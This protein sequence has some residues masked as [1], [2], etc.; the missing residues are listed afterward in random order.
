MWGEEND[1]ERSRPDHQSSCWS[2]GS[3]ENV[4]TAGTDDNLKTCNKSDDML[5]SDEK[6][7]EV[8]HF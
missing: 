4:D 8:V 2:C 6:Q 3:D 7:S 5:P 1:N